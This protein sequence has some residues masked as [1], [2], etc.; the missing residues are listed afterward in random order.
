MG[1]C[2]K[3]RQKNVILGVLEEN[4]YLIVLY[5]ENNFCLDYLNSLDSPLKTA[6]IEGR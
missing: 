4:F 5:K 3:N 2:L 6:K 1:F